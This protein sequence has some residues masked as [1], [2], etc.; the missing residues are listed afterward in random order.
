[1]ASLPGFAGL[2]PVASPYGKPGPY[3]TPL[4]PA[5]QTGFQ[6]WIKQN[7]V[8]YDPAP[9]ADYDMPGFYKALQS[10]DPIAKTAI[11]ATDHLPHYPDKWKTPFH[12]SFSNESQYALPGAPHWEEGDLLVP[13]VQRPIPP[14]LK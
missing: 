10:G 2:K 8:P 13:S 3:I 11:N 6:G 14:G 12:K 7:H 1:M 9:T 4:T 5:E